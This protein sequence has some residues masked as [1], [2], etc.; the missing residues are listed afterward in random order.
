M[1]TVS[2]SVSVSVSV[3]SPLG[4]PPRCAFSRPARPLIDRRCTSAYPTSLRPAHLKSLRLSRPAG[5]GGPSVCGISQIESDEDEQIAIS[6]PGRLTAALSAAVPSMRAQQ[7]PFAQ[8]RRLCPWC[9]RRSMPLGREDAPKFGQ[10]VPECAGR[11]GRAAQRRSAVA[12]RQKK[13]RVR[14]KMPA[15]IPK[16]LGRH[17]R[18]FSTAECYYFAL[19][20]SA[21]QKGL[22]FGAKTQR[23]RPL[24]APSALST[25][26][27]EIG[28]GPLP[29]SS[30]NSH[31]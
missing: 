5:R 21:K 18:C 15:R 30:A 3:S 22:N 29:I 24:C 17:F 19:E 16:Q 28:R 6:R 2:I 14:P 12:H 10:S 25:G 20:W 7:P 23:L 31:L 11:W 26:R 9:A 1:A 27:N 13:E 8:R 4:S